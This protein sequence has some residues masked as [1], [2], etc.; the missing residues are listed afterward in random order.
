MWT[1]LMKELGQVSTADVAMATFNWLMC[2]FGPPYTID[3]FNELMMVCRRHHN[4]KLAL[5]VFDMLENGGLKPDILSYNLAIEC[6]KEDAVLN[7][8]TEGCDR[9]YRLFERMC[10]AGTPPN[11]FTFTSLIVAC[12]CAP[13][14]RWR[15]ASLTFDRMRN[16]LRTNPGQDVVVEEEFLKLC[17]SATR[18]VSLAEALEIYRT[19]RIHGLHDRL[20]VYKGLLQVKV[21]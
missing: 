2:H 12:R 6:C 15:Q 11:S 13:S 10:H 16:T 17:I 8:R 9:A 18:L 14:T 4:F 21:P 7:H 5:R 19:L 3:A 20:S 1:S